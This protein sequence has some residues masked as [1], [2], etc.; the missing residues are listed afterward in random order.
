MRWFAAGARVRFARVAA[1][2]LHEG[3][4]SHFGT[5]PAWVGG[6]SYVSSSTACRIMTSRS[7]V[8]SSWCIS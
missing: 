5:G 3:G 4:A 6:V 8:S 2:Y 1:D 7:S